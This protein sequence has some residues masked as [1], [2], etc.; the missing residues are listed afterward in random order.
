MVCG[1][2]DS[3]GV[4]GSILEL[5]PRKVPC[6]TTARENLVSQGRQQNSICNSNELATPI[7]KQLNP[8]L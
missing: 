7:R 2:R 8:S 4:L 1:G 3:G 5:L 6:P